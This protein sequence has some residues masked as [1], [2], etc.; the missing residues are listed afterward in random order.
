EARGSPVELET[1]RAALVRLDARITGDTWRASKQAL[2]LETATPGFWD[3]ADRFERLGRAEYLDRIENSLRS[4]AS[5]LERLY[6]GPRARV[7]PRAA[8][9]PRAGRARDGSLPGPRDRRLRRV[10]APRPGGWA[11]RVG[12]G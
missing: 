10:P 7:A 4:A 1:L 11:P 5:L 6:G 3:R 9:L 2:L 8:R 12:V